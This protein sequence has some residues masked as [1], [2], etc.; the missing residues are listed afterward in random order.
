[1]E[2]SA[3]QRVEDELY[4][5][6]QRIKALMDFLYSEKVNNVSVTMKS[7]MHEQLRAMQEYGRILTDRLAIW[8]L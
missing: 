1:M 2:V 7:L 3:K 6:R 8:G 4:E 5:L